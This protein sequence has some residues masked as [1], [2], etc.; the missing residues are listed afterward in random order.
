MKLIHV[1]HSPRRASVAVLLVAAVL[2]TACGAGNTGTWPGITVSGEQI[3][4]SYGQRIAAIDSATGARIWDYPPKDDRDTTF[5]AIPVEVDG[6]VYVGDYKGR[7]HAIDNDGQVKWIYEREIEKLIGPLALEAPDRVIAGIAVSEDR[8]FVGMGSRDVIALDRETGALD[9]EF[10]TDHGV[11][12]SPLYLPANADGNDGEATLYVASLDHSFYALDPETGN[13]RWDIDLGAAAPGDMLYD[14]DRNLIYVGTFLSE[15]LAIDLS[16]ESIA[17][18]YKAEGWLWDKPAIADDMLYFGDLKGFV[19]A[20]RITD[21]GFQQ[22]WKLPVAEEPIR[23]TPALTNGLVI[24]GSEDKTVYALSQTDGAISWKATTSGPAL[25]SIIPIES[26]GGDDT[27][28]VVVGTTEN[29][30]LVVAL[31]S[32]SGEVDWRYSNED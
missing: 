3:L 27:G 26:T 22:K 24:A 31:N 12:S 11:W 5:S 10:E 9:W 4:V 2:L 25:T 23:G 18:R 13:K 19:Y 16:S 29:D 30:A 15:M 14:A 1:F 32:A 28:I 6:V 8:V 17:A 21:D 20:V 7:V